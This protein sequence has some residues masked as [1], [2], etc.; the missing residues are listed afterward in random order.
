MARTREG[1]VGLAGLTTVILGFG[2]CALLGGD[3]GN[4][5]DRFAGLLLPIKNPT[6][7]AKTSLAV[8]HRHQLTCQ[9]T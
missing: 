2:G 3:L 4:I 6:N 9:L 8:L 7:L 5:P 1:G